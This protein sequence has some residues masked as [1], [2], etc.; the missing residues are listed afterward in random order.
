MGRDVAQS[1]GLGAWVAGA[2]PRTLAAALAPVAVGTGVAAGFGEAKAP[3]AVLA[4]IVA[5]GLQVGVN[6]ANDYSDGLRGTDAERVGPTRLVASGLASPKAVRHAAIASIGVAGVAGLVLAVLVTPWLIVVGAACMVAAWTYTGGPWPYGYKGFG[7]LFVFLCFGVVATVGTAYV[8][9]DRLSLVA[10]V[11][12]VPTGLLAVALL[13]VNNLRDLAGDAAS[14]K[15]TLSV[16]VGERWA[17]WMVA[18]EIEAAFLVVLVLAIFVQ[19][20]WAALAL[21]AL[22][23]GLRAT[24]SVLSGASGRAL[25]GALGRAA[26]AQVAV[27][28]LLGLGLGLGR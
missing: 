3:E 2:R 14:G 15:R 22:P 24:W 1:P 21:L 7:E 10:L 26:L 20:P 11:A 25:I 4:G 6:Y 23:L 27:A 5:I 19:R 9:M 8:Q 13:D 12:S 16:R 28:V 18:F 17:R